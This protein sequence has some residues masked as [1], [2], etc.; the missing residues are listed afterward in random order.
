MVKDKLF[1]S[2]AEKFYNLKVEMGALVRQVKDKEN[3]LLVGEGKQKVKEETPEVVSTP[4]VEVKPQEPE[5]KTTKPQQQERPKNNQFKKPNSQFNNN[6]FNNKKP[7]NNNFKQNNQN[8]NANKNPNFKANNK[9]NQKPFNKDNKQRPAI[10]YA[11]PIIVASPARNFNN[12][13]KET[14]FEEKHQY[15]KRDLLK[16]GMIEEEESN[17]EIVRKNR[18]KK[19]ETAPQVVQDKPQGPA[20]INTDNITIKLL[21]EVSGKPVS[22]IIKK[23]MLLD[24][25]I[26]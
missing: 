22:E 10:N 6:Q 25:N 24:G 15:S 23:F 16:R 26:L 20:I 19:K 13:K 14:H 2:L 17:R 12:K 21:S 7:F 18:V 1:I 5:T 11:Q 3:E 9:P 8:Q 4:K